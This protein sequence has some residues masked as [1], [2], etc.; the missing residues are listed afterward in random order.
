MESLHC[1]NCIWTRWCSRSCGTCGAYKYWPDILSL[2]KSMTI[3][4]FGSSVS[5]ADHS[6]HFWFSVGRWSWLCVLPL[7]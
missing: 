4:K 3:N 7:M 6:L 2:T 1:H 5:G